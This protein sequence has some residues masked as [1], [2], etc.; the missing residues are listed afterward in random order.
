MQKFENKTNIHVVSFWS[1][2]SHSSLYVRFGYQSSWLHTDLI[3]FHQKL[4]QTLEIIR[5]FKVYESKDKEEKREMQLKVQR[6][7]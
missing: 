4:F 2:Y 7:L 3:F 1:K 5:T 6:Q